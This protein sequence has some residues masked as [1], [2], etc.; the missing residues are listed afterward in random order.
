MKDIQD[1]I[2]EEFEKNPEEAM[3]LYDFK[4]VEECFPHLLKAQIAS[5]LE[6]LDASQKATIS[7]RHGHSLNIQSD[8]YLIN[9]EGFDLL[10]QFIKLNL[11]WATKLIDENKKAGDPDKKFLF[12]ALIQNHSRS[13]LVAEEILHLLKGG[14]PDAAFSRWRSLYELAVVTTFIF[15]NGESCA[16]AYIDHEVVDHLKC[17]ELNKKIKTERGFKTFSD[18]VLMAIKK[19]YQTKLK[20]YGSS[21]KNAYGW[22]S[23]G[24]GLKNPQFKDLEEGNGQSHMRVYYKQASHKVHAGSNGASSS[25]GTMSF[26]KDA[27]MLRAPSHEGLSVSAILCVHSLHQ[28]TTTLTSLFVHA[29][30]LIYTHVLSEISKKVEEVF[31][32]EYSSK[33]V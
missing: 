19:D 4:T 25:L 18:T 30:C 22:A 2:D 21:F 7:E 16:E 3:R 28:V 9:K 8:I 10:E 12:H 31:D 17:E 23:N 20:K 29:E 15:R 14:Y 5:Q 32:R 1:Y 11:D 13:C 27:P 33:S 6:A 26:K 24:L